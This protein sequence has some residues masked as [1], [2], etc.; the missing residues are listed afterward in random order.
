MER[1]G[2]R[3]W[4]SL[5]LTRF[6]AY[7]S[8]QLLPLVNSVKQED[9]H[10]LPIINELKGKTCLGNGLGTSDWAATI[11]VS[12]WPLMASVR[13]LHCPSSSP[14]PLHCIWSLSLVHSTSW[15]LAQ[16]TPIFLLTLSVVNTFQAYHSMIASLLVPY[17]HS[18]L[19]HLSISECCF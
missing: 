9:R 3:V 18:H 5:S 7:S 12:H 4:Y 13:P 19:P 8:W 10:E 11:C 15:T 17:L 6:P 16:S 1:E 14:P 2:W